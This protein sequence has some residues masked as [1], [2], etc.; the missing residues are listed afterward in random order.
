MHLNNLRF[1]TVLL[2]G[3]LCVFAAAFTS[4]SYGFN[5]SHPIDSENTYV[6]A[7]GSCPPWQALR[8]VCKNDVDL[9]VST[10][11][12]TMGI[13]PGNVKEL[14]NSEAAYGGVVKGFKW[15]KESASEDSTVIVY[16]NG[17]GVLLDGIDGKSKE[18]VFVLWSQDFPFAGL[19]AVMAKIWMTDKE[20]SD[21][22]A[23]VPGRAKLVVADTC[24]A[25][26]AEEYLEYKG[27]HTDYGLVDTA[28]LAAAEAGQLAFATGDYG[29]FTLRLSDA[30]RNSSNLEE[31]FYK[32]RLR[33]MEESKDICKELKDKKLKDKCK[34]QGPTI[35]DPLGIVKLFEL[36]VKK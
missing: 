28:L 26:G 27:K 16:Y 12:R 2:F 25:G 23:A 7:I 20:F 29:L 9:F 3:V 4:L 35:D 18:E 21:L 22:L 17:H 31:A 24:H 13:P 14:V 19:Y 5:K 8:T 11:V 32:A 15:L 33:T 30:M 6:L 36:N 10:V 1:K 34:E